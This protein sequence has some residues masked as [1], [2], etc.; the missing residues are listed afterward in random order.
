MSAEEIFLLESR[1]NRVTKTVRLDE[2]LLRLIP[3]GNR[4]NEKDVQCH[5]GIRHREIKRITEQKWVESVLHSGY[6]ELQRIVKEV[7]LV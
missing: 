5:V 3:F 7:I 4:R 2:R 1:H 6:D